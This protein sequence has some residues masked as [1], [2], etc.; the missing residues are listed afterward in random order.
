MSKPRND[1][2]SKRVS[3]TLAIDDTDRAE[4]GC[5][6]H[7]ASLILYELRD[8]I[9]LVDAPLLVR[10]A[11]GVPW[12][13]RGNASV[14]I[15][16]LLTGG[17]T[18][19]EILEVAWNLASEYSKGRRGEAHKGPGVAL[20]KGNKPWTRI[21]LRRIYLQAVSGLV[22]RSVI[23][24]VAR[25]E[26]IVF[27]GGRGVVGAISSLASL[28][29]WDPYSY[30]L[31]AY[32]RPENWGSRRLFREDPLFE[33]CLPPCV[34]NNFDLWD[35]TLVS[36]PRGPDPVLAG[37]RGY[38]REWLGCYSLVLAEEP[39]HWVLFRS[40]QHTDTHYRGFPMLTG[41]LT[42]YSSTTLTI[43][44]Q[45]PPRVLPKQHV[46]IEAETRSPPHPNVRDE[47]Y[48]AFYRESHPLNTIARLLEPGD[49]LRVSGTARPYPSPQKPTLA[50]E[51]IHWMKLRE[52]RR[53]VNPRCPKCGARMK[54]LGRRGGFKCPKCGFKLSE[55]TRVSVLEV[56]KPS[57]SQISPRP[58]GLR[59][60][61]RPS[62]APPEILNDISES[63]V[64][65]VAF[66]MSIGGDPPP[67]TMPCGGCEC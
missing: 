61:S 6:T 17:L 52:K 37:F 10:L 47:I 56:R 62:W 33:S 42:P 64:Y 32:R 53:L 48:L 67:S 54:S 19:E 8:R 29:P 25:K 31:I 44:I 2:H 43:E 26:G 41:G 27:R 22:D 40:N 57:S 5:T 12:K 60:L 28:A 9:E 7:L 18:L 55:A 14:V 51:K 1:Y 30:E 50:V 4:G 20:Y 23:E 65:S 59:H 11:P 39:S 3:F 24:R 66:F 15:R 35:H 46:I 13:T 63:S 34:F 38:C 45:S 16:G 58:Y 49:I 36:A 21:S